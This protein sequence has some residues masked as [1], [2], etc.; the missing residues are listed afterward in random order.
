MKNAISKPVNNQP[1][2]VIVWSI[3]VIIFLLLI[4]TAFIGYVLPW[5]QMSFWAATV[6]TNMLTAIPLIGQSL[7]VQLLV[8]SGFGL[9]IISEGLFFVAWFWAFFHCTLS[10]SIELGGFV[11]SNCVENIS[12]WGVPWFNT[13][14][15]LSS[16]ATV[17]SCHHSLMSNR[18]EASLTSLFATVCLAMIFTFW[19]A[20]EYQTTYL[21]ISDG[22]AGSTFFLATGFHGIHVVIGTIFLTNKLSIFRQEQE[23][24]VSVQLR[25]N[26]VLTDISE[27][28]GSFY[29]YF[30]VR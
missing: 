30:N 29:V 26:N 25:S 4:I 14:L 1:P 15:L 17:T 5:G 10:A 8:K 13:V 7:A 23:I 20:Y 3:G 22:A 11:P 18:H 9:F 21:D 24:S 16:G 6:I 19:Q 27:S 28:F 2:S 12:T